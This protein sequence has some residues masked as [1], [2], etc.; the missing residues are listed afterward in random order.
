MGYHLNGRRNPQKQNQEKEN[1]LNHV[2]E[3]KVPEQQIKSTPLSSDRKRVSSLKQ[4]KKKR[5]GVT[6]K[7][8]EKMLW[9]KAQ[10]ELQDASSS[11]WKHVLPT[12][13]SNPK[14]DELENFCAFVN[15][16]ERGIT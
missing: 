13:L 5:K 8:S 9:E 1:R 16:L 2:L 10:P 4:K 7:H 3:C 12:N 15:A 14:A 11:G 6:T